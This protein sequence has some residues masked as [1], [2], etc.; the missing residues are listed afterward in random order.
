MLTPSGLSVEPH[1]MPLVVPDYDFDNQN[2]WGGMSIAAGRY[3]GSSIQT[4]D[5][6]GQP[7]DSQSDNND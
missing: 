2:R 1:V 5:H 7:K 4:F 3:T 6:K